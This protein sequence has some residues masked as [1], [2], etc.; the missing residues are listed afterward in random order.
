M[1]DS[2]LLLL[3][4]LPRLALGWLDLLLPLSLAAVLFR[5][6]VEAPYGGMAIAAWLLI[7]LLARRQHYPWTLLLAA[8]VALQLREVVLPPAGIYSSPADFL[9]LLAA[10][11]VAYGRS[12]A[13][14]QRTLLV[15]LGIVAAQPAVSTL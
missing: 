8:L 13:Q 11:A 7:G 10:F 3:K 4:A 2:R 6:R 1:P 15:M 9:V 12:V 14:W 5:G